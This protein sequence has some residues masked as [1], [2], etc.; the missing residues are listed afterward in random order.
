M[1][2]KKLKRFGHTDK[3]DSALFTC[4]NYKEETKTEGQEENK[5]YIQIAAFDPG[6]VNTG[7]RIERRELTE[8]IEGPDG[9]ESKV[10]VKTI[11]QK[12][13]KSG[14][15]G[16][17]EHY[18]VTMRKHIM[19]IAKD[20][21][22]CDYILIE[23]QMRN[24]PEATRMSQ[25]IISTLLGVIEGSKALIIEIL[26]T[27][28]SRAFGI[29][30]LKGKELKVWAVQQALKILD[31]RGD[32]KGEGLI[33]ETKKKDDHADVVLY[34]DAWYRFLLTDKFAP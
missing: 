24:N 4:I 12:L 1:S 27:V 17:T 11:V 13:F 19:S 29:S 10:I 3:F 16:S 9:S 7:C 34:C 5:S 31:E 22:E 32:I 33:K 25:H 8:G 28:K 2:V 6:V 23:S 26:P 20:I 14:A 21:Y 18:F 15:K 30:K